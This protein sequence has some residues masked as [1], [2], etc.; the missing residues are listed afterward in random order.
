[1]FSKQTDLALHQITILVDDYN[2]SVVRESSSFRSTGVTSAY[3]LRSEQQVSVR[4]VMLNS[5]SELSKSGTWTRN[6]ENFDQF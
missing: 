4:L 1:M 5:L 6:R 3:H 2:R